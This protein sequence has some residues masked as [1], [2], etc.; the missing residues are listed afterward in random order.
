MNHSVVGS[1]TESSSKTQINLEQLRWD[2][3]RVRG[4]NKRRQFQL[5]DRSIGLGIISLG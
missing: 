2:Y 4:L 1:T 3:V 5:G